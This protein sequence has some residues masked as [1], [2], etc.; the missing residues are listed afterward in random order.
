M[1]PLNAVGANAQWLD[2]PRRKTWVQR[3]IPLWPETIKAIADVKKSRPQP[4]DHADLDLL[5][6]GPRGESYVGK[7][8]GYRVTQAFDL[9]AI[10]AGVEGRTFYDFR[11][12]F[13][14]IG[15]GT[16]DLAAVRAIMGHAAPTNDMSSIYRQEISD[17]RLKAVTNQVHAWLW[18][19]KKA[20]AKTTGTTQKK[21]GAK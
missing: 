11:R 14:T 13:Q 5:F 21:R 12:T 6:I 4:K 15:E 16:N 17:E 10:K 18:P 1:L 2:Y 8:K 9:I 3:R 19:A 7:L 20:T